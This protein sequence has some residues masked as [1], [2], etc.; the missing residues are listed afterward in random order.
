MD[1]RV[2]L[3]KE[4]QEDLNRVDE[5]NMELLKRSLM[6]SLEA[7]TVDHPVVPGPDV[8]EDGGACHAM[9]PLPPTPPPSLSLSW[10]NKGLKMAGKVVVEGE[11]MLADSVHR[12]FLS[13]SSEAESS[14]AGQAGSG[15]EEEAD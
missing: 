9:L 3:A 14:E 6:A 15:E 8:A 4:F 5:E 12:L 11:N 7:Q 2:A 10:T 13:F 1:I